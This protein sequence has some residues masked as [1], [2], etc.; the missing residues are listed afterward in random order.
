MIDVV[1]V[2]PYFFAESKDRSIFKYP[3]LGLGYLA[4]TL[5]AAGFSVE[6]VDGSYSTRLDVVKRVKELRP[7]ILGFYCMM[8]MEQAALNLGGILK[9][10]CD[11]L[12]TGGPYP[13]ADPAK[14]LGVFD[15]A[16]I[17]EGERTLTE[18]AEAVIRGRGNPLTI[19]GVAYLT[20]DGIKKTKSRKRVDNLDELPFPSRDLFDNEGYKKY[21]RR[22]YGYTVTSMMTTRGCPYS[23]GFCSKPIFGSAVKTR[24]AENVL[25]ELEDIARRGYDRVWMGDDCFTIDDRR[26][27][28]ICQGIIDRGLS[29]T[30][31][32][33]SR[34]DGVNDEVLTAMRDAGCA[35]L[36]FGL[37]SGD[38]RILRTMKK[39]ATFAEGKAAIEL[40]GRNGI[41]TGAF[42]ILGY[43]GETNESLTRTVNASSELP[44]DYLS[45]TV[46]YPLP[47]TDLYEKVK[48][49][50]KTATWTSPRRHTLLYRGDFSVLKL[51]AAMAKGLTQHTL[52]AR[53]DRI[54][55][56]P[57]KVFRRATDTILSLLR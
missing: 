13:S 53:N 25:N 35:R 30:W 20:G 48:D 34:V 54:G 38:D 5:Q 55:K 32:C 31:E 16:V 2:Y 7:K 47:G 44:L 15:L 45:Y 26:T 9:N 14:F 36:F 40:A 17:G 46:P 43:P 10:D 22:E 52:L 24:S 56:I 29:L 28:A 42:F 49:R 1:L 57:E 33:L 39:R 50:L 11:L 41:R 6:I 4:A 21:W 51:K 23:C 3:P 18:L 27:I 8:T 37:E 12:I 19:A